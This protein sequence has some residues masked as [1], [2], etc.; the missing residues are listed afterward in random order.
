MTTTSGHPIRSTPITIDH[1]TYENFLFNRID[2][3]DQVTDLW[4]AVPDERERMLDLMRALI[5]E[6]GAPPEQLE[7][8]GLS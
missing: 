8:L 7:R 2:D 3:P 5:A 6:E 4:D 1:R